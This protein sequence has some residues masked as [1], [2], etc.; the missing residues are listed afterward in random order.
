[1]VMNGDDDGDGDGDDD[2]DENV[3]NIVQLQAP[4]LFSE[5]VRAGACQAGINFDQVL[6]F[7]DILLLLH[8]DVHKMLLK[9]F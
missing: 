6:S 4:K 1:M 7:A 8:T 2:G 3:P 5:V 9:L